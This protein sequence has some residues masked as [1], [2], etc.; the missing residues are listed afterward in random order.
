MDLQLID[1]F[2][3]L[4]VQLH[5]ELVLRLDELVGRQD[6]ALV[7]E[8][9][10]VGGVGDLR[11]SVL[12]LKSA[13]ALP[14]NILLIEVSDI[15]VVE[16]EPAVLL[17]LNERV[18]VPAFGGSG[19]DD[20]SL[21]RVLGVNGGVVALDVV[22][23]VEQLREPQLRMHLDLIALDRIIDNPLQVEHHYLW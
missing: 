9:V 21:E 5:C 14:L 8:D 2:A 3:V 11:P 17:G 7:E 10:G 19:V 20:H 6:A 16:L 12:G 22:L 1:Q 13:E 4:L 15:L 23:E 18:V